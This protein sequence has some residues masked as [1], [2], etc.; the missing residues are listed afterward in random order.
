MN[1]ILRQGNNQHHEDDHEEKKAGA[2]RQYDNNLNYG[3]L[4]K[5]EDDEQNEDIYAAQWSQ[6]QL[7]D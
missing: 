2:S 3:S 4:I 7:Q 1:Q 5:V 6:P